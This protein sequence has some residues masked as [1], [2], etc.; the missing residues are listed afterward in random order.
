M[1]NLNDI[2]Y[3]DEI[4]RTTVRIKKLY[5]DLIT[6][7][8]ESFNDEE[9]RENLIKELEKNL[10]WEEKLHQK[11]D[12][13]SRLDDVKEEL[14]GKEELLGFK[15]QYR[16]ILTGEKVN[17]LYERIKQK[18]Y[19]ENH[20][21]DD[22]KEY[23]DLLLEE[24]LKNRD[25]EQEIDLEKMKAERDKLISVRKYLL[26]DLARA[27]FSFLND[28]LNDPAYEE[29]KEDLIKL[30]YKLAFLDPELEE[31][32]IDQDFKNSDTYLVTSVFS[33]ELNTGSRL[34]YEEL[35]AEIAMRETEFHR[36][37]LLEISD[38]ELA[39]NRFS[40]LKAIYCQVKL[41]SALSFLKKKDFKEEKNYCEE[42]YDPFYDSLDEEYRDDKNYE[43]VS[44]ILEKT[45]NNFK[46][47]KTKRKILSIR[48]P[49]NKKP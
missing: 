11:I 45:F 1:D 33:S 31:V 17:A 49:K 13:L 29:F 44:S 3:I 20:L 40:M 25:E 6:Y 48:P 36:N 35:V 43:I 27:F 41:K 46:E 34:M 26:N 8:L 42:Y 47:Y 24:Y 15:N 32:A 19:K 14:W 38:E 39:E 2:V 21:M 10:L 23:S 30:K 7:E 16:S 28:F 18:S 9:L 12:L 22:V 5:D 4:I 37:I